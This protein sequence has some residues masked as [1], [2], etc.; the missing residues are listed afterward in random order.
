M[1]IQFIWVILMTN[2]SH[3]R[4]WGDIIIMSLLIIAIS[5]PFHHTY[6]LLQ[7]FQLHFLSDAILGSA[8]WIPSLCSCNR[9]WCVRCYD[10]VD[11]INV[12]LLSWIVMKYNSKY[13][14]VRICFFSHLYIH[15]NGFAI[16]WY[17]IFWKGHFHE[18]YLLI[19]HSVSEGLD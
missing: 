13:E 1:Q 7:Y 15:I 12:A 9:H 19:T 16:I 2:S 8:R 14:I 11:I 17:F 6:P 3:K 10:F 5:L 18:V 4:Q